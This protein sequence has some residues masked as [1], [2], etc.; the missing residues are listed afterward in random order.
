MIPAFNSYVAKLDAILKPHLA[1]NSHV[2]AFYSLLSALCMAV[3][4]AL[5]V[6]LNVFAFVISFLCCC[7]KKKVVPTVKSNKIKAI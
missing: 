1:E 5:V 6:A 2:V 3:F 7:G 4:F